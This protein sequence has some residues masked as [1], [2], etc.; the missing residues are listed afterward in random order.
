MRVEK[1]ESEKT[2]VYA[3]KLRQK[4]QFKNSISGEGWRQ[5]PSLAGSP[6]PQQSRGKEIQLMR[7]G[8]PE[9]GGD[10]RHG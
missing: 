7:S 5:S 1:L 3:Q 10:V 8:R 4:M 6:S 2:R 9:T